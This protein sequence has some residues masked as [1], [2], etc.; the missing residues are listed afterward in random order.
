ML[1]RV[2]SYELRSYSSLL[3]VFQH[4]IIIQQLTYVLTT[5]CEKV[6]LVFYFSLTVCYVENFTEV[7]NWPL[8][9]AAQH[10]SMYVIEF[11]FTI[12]N[13]NVINKAL[14][15]SRNSLSYWLCVSLNNPVDTSSATQGRAGYFTLSAVHIPA[16]SGCGSMLGFTALHPWNDRANKDRI[17]CQSETIS[18]EIPSVRT[19]T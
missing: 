18:K 10:C 5:I 1:C 15:Y 4:S 6:S 13:Y 17:E 16:I 14:F 11:H 12:L 19:P 7:R 8:F 2:I 3:S 9:C